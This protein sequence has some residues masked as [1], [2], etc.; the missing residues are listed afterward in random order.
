MKSQFSADQNPTVTPLRVQEPQLLEELKVEDSAAPPSAAI[1][2]EEEKK[3][4]PKCT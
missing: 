4:E 1:I 2:I 3:D